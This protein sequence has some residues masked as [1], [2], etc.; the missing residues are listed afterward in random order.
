MAKSTDAGRRT[1]RRESSKISWIGAA[2]ETFG[3]LISERAN[4]FAKILSVRHSAARHLFWHFNCL[5]DTLELHISNPAG[6]AC[7]TPTFSL[8]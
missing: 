8:P 4:G 1:A 2:G 3:W 5:A 7:S 6:D